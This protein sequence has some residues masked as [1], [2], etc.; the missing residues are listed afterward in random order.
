MPEAVAWIGAQLGTAGSAIGAISASKLFVVGSLL[1]GQAAKR[2]AQRKAR[3]AYIDNLESK[4]ATGVA[5][6]ASP[7]RYVYGRDKVGSNIVAMLTSGA[8][9]QY[10]HLVCVFANHEVHAV[11]EVYLGGKAVGYANLSSGWAT[12]GGDQDV[13]V[14]R[15]NVVTFKL[16]SGYSNL[17]V[18]RGTDGVSYGTTLALGTH[19][20][21]TSDVI[22]LTSYTAVTDYIQI[23]FS[24]NSFAKG[25]MTAKTGPNFAGPTYTIP[26]AGF[27]NLKVVGSK[28]GVWTDEFTFE[29]G[30][31]YTIVGSLITITTS[32][33]VGYVF[34]AVYSYPVPTSYVKIGTHL[35]AAPDTVDSYLN[36]QCPGEWTSNHKLSGHAYLVVTLDL[37]HSDFQSGPVDVQVDCSGKKL[38]DPRTA[39]TAWSD[40]NAL[41]IRDYLLSP[42][43]GIPAAVLNATDI[44]AT[45]VTAANDCDAM[46]IT[47]NGATAKR[48]TF[49][50]VVTAE[51][52]AAD[53]LDAMAASMA[54]SINGADWSVRAGVY[55]DPSSATPALY[56]NHVDDVVGSLTVAPGLPRSD[57]FN[58]VK[59]RY[60]GLETKYVATDITPYVDATYRSLDGEELATEM[61]FSY[62][63]NMQRCHNLA[64]IELEDSRK[65]L[66]ISADFSYKAWRIRPGDRVMFTSPSTLLN[67]SN[68]VFRV[69]DKSFSFGGPVK[70]TLKEDQSSV[71]DTAPTAALDVLLNSLLDY[72]IMSTYTTTVFGLT[73]NSGDDH[74]LID[75][76]GSITS[77]IYVSWINTIG[78]SL[79]HIELQYMRQSETAWTT[80]VV[81]GA[82][83]YTYV[84]PVSDGAVYFIRARIVNTAYNSTG[85]WAIITHTVVGK[86]APP[87]NYD[88]F[89]VTYSTA[90]QRKFNFA[91]TSNT[92]P[93]DLAGMEIRYVQGNVTTP[94]WGSMTK[95][96]NGLI[97]SSPYDEQTLYPGTYTFAICAVDTTGN[98]STTP[99][100]YTT[101]LPQ[102]PEGNVIEE[103]NT[104]RYGW[105]SSGG[106][107][108]TIGKRLGDA[109]VAPTTAWSN[110]G[111]TWGTGIWAKG[112]T[113]TQLIVN[114]TMYFNAPITFN[115]GMLVDA[116]G[117][118]VYQYA[119]KDSL[120][121]TQPT[122]GPWY[123][124]TPDTTIKTTEIYLAITVN[125]NTA[126]SKP[127]LKSA[128]VK[129]FGVRR[130][131]S[132]KEVTAADPQGISLIGNTAYLNT[133]DVAHQSEF[134][135]LVNESG[136]W[137][138][139]TSMRQPTTTPMFAEPVP[140]ISFYKNGVPAM[141]SSFNLDVI[142]YGTRT[143]D[144]DF[145]WS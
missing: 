2:R 33:P 56:L 99:L 144:G 104:T 83:P 20:T 12:Y 86:S 78:K 84:G 137:T 75:T 106:W 77:R 40:N 57:I 52:T 103:R 116:E 65:G 74:L 139:E 16:P 119:Y 58:T 47:V 131:V 141:P 108:V 43:C 142:G 48:Y 97:I 28:N 66:T 17:V 32:Y 109:V 69:T 96:H 11:H 110:L 42:I 7:I 87:A 63:N 91:Y 143:L 24:P 67:M 37:N 15:G 134:N 112:S 82:D 135:I 89:T 49:N 72:A 35:G 129:V 21:V 8:N 107:F 34:R 14:I 68:R 50:G 95:L 100:Y 92:K 13:Q 1:Y 41:V 85:P 38:Y 36:S 44:N 81:T 121:T 111:T 76:S 127:R 98:Y 122:S 94:A 105:T 120:G 130:M 126:Y 18:K 55:N 80:Q 51:E 64:A 71:W 88:T 133:T 136:S 79:S 145:I 3:Q 113:A 10:R 62:T 102:L 25:E 9:D 30:A 6:T 123:T 93:L 60:T 54:G 140:Y 101:S 115:L 117:D 73:A 22:T 132:Y 114:L 61:S 125:G 29:L 124:L 31:N 45:F 46:A 128:V 90:G 23:A 59:G 26:D 39:T 4:L 5:T 53:V 138:W 27:T 70:L 19:Y 118:V